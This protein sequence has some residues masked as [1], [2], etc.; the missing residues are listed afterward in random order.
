M[1]GQTDAADRDVPAAGHADD[2]IN[3]AR[4]PTTV[5]IERSTGRMG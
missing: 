3:G 4:L 2:A 5:M 1:T